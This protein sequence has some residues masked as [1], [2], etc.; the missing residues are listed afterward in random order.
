MNTYTTGTGQIIQYVHDEEEACGRFGCPIHSPSDHH[1]KD[2]PTN[3][4]DGGWLDIKP[5]HFERICEHG[6]GHPDPDSAAYLLRV[7]GE[8]VNVHGCDGCC[9]DPEAD[10]PG[11]LTTSSR[12]FDGFSEF[13]TA[14]GHKIQVYES[15]SVAPSLWLKVDGKNNSC[16][17]TPG[18]THVL[19]RL[20]QA[21][22]L[23]D[24]LDYMIKHHYGREE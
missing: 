18:E 23:R 15:S 24:Q 6:I 7:F 9:R 17:D 13:T 3:W 21:E 14:Y 16:G 19:L 8:D 5:A 10:L 20:S 11:E 1:M 2:W 4:R 22:K 12:G